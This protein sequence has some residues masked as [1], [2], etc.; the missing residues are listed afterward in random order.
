VLE[1]AVV[2]VVAVA[3][4]GLLAAGYTAARAEDELFALQF[5]TP[6]VARAETLTERAGRATAGQ[7]RRLLLARVRLRGGDAAGAVALLRR[8]VREEPANA[9]AWLGL[10]RAARP[11]DPDLARRAAQRVRELVPPVPLP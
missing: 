5:R 9:E 3:A 6:D 8:A 4:A 10:A 1:R 2:I 11:T 7:R